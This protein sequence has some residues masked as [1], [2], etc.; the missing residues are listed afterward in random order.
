MCKPKQA[1]I[2]NNNPNPVDVFFF[3][4]HR[5]N[6]MRQ[7][8]SWRA[9]RGPLALLLV[10]LCVCGA[11]VW[12]YVTSLDSDITETLVSRS[13]L[14]SPQPRVYS[15]PCSEDYANYK[16]YPGEAPFLTTVCVTCAAAIMVLCSHALV[17]LRSPKNILHL[18]YI[19]YNTF[20]YCSQS[21]ASI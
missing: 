5:G 20:L 8:S 19:F 13:D 12:I 4:L 21:P 14:V 11:A 6:A 16:R 2:V 1:T 10:T 17:E 18:I 7:G 9:S 3:V 15:V